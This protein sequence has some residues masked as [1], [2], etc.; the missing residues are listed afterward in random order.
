MNAENKALKPCPFCGR[1]G[2]YIVHNIEMEPDGITCP[3]CHIIIRFPRIKVKNG[4]RFGVAMGKM[5][6]A[7]NRRMQP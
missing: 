4:E 1:D 7:W 5:T 2:A 3:T 6:E